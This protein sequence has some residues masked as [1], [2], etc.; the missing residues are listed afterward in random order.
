MNEIE[1]RA[2]N[3]YIES[4]LLDLPNFKPMSFEEISSKLKAEGIEKSSSTVHRWSQKY[5]WESMLAVK[6][7]EIKA[8]DDGYKKAI[9]NQALSQKVKSLSLQ[10]QKQETIK[11]S[12]L[13]KLST[14][15]EM[16]EDGSQNKDDRKFIIQAIQTMIV[17]DNSLIKMPDDDNT[18]RLSLDEVAK[19]IYSSGEIIDVEIEDE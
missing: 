17:A 1:Q 8:S 15:V 12:L 6:V 11:T 5:Q 4:A 7:D 10:S 18:P 3:L 13:D 19:K 14:M 16:V 2:Y 9:A